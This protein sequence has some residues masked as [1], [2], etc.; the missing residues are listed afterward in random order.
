VEHWGT[1]L[2]QKR[3]K[4]EEDTAKTERRWVG[5][6]RGELSQRERGPVEERMGG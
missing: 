2:V 4:K 1:A 6:K 5:G 3:K